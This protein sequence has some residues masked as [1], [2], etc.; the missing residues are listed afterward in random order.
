MQLRSKL[1][2]AVMLFAMPLL[3]ATL[4]TQSYAQKKVSAKPA[5]DASLE[6]TAVGYLDSAI[7]EL[8][9]VEDLS[10]RIALSEE[11]VKLLAKRNPARCRQ[12]LDNLFETAMQTTQ[13]NSKAAGS[14]Q[15]SNRNAIVKIVK[16]AAFDKK[17][18]SSYAERYARMGED[19]SNGEVNAAPSRAVSGL[20][21]QLATELVEKDATLATS[22]AEKSLG[23]GVLPATL[24]FIETLRGKDVQLA[25]RFSLSALQSIQSRHGTDINELFL[26]YSY[27]FS[28]LRVPLI[29]PE[30]G[31]AL[32]QIPALVKVASERQVDPVL[33]G[34]Y[35]RLASQTVLDVER[36]TVHR[37]ELV[38]GTVGDLYFLTLIE[39]QVARYQPALGAA[40]AKQ[41]TFLLHGLEPEQRLAAQ[42]GAEK[43]KAPG[44]ESQKKAGGDPAS[45]DSML[46]RAD[47]L[48]NP[49]QKDRLYYMAANLAVQTKNYELALQIVEK[50]SDKSRE[51]AQQFIAF[52]IAEAEIK[53]G[54]LERAEQIA[55]RDTDMVRRAYLFTLIAD[56]L[57]SGRSKDTARATELL[58]QV[59][60]ITAK[61]E[62]NQEK[63]ST[64]TGAAAAYIRF[65]EQRATELLRE[66]IQV[67]NKGEGFTGE[68]VVKRSL[69][70]G[71]F[72]FFYRMYDTSLTFT[73]I[74]KQQGKKNFN[75]TLAD[76]LT[77][78]SR[79]ARLKALIALCGGVLSQQAA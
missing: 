34:E 44:Q 61:I 36:Y 20:Y 17:L 51:A 77:V 8:R 54:Q 46:R 40:L 53:D 12:L 57:L 45:L 9:E 70:L 78:K 68:T 4:A 10:T 74:L 21:L 50:L 48:S 41:Q 15:T 66:A 14:S 11:V 65:D 49:T 27:V 79:V 63:F 58:Q 24:V 73:D 13:A 67:A 19:K 39:P 32:Q 1:N 35:L 30:V 60:Q 69:M 75:A 28:P 6:Q 76:V 56:A 62:S 37:Q 7:D 5:R 59:E 3:C 18:A 31:I 16:L 23:G 25:D 29:V 47:A 26:L 22:V 43:W 2:S 55:R 64:L 72:G 71:D 33:A 38:A 52:S 42:T